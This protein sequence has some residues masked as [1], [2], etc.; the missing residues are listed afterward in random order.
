M[1]L[2]AV[3]LLL[4]VAPPRP[5]ARLAPLVAVA[6]GVAAGAALSVVVVRRRPG[7]A[8]PRLRTTV[9][10]AKQLVLGLCATNEEIVWRRIA[11]GELLPAGALV[12]LGSSSVGFA[13]VHRKSRLLHVGT[14]CTFGVVY[15]ATGG[16]GASVAAHWAY[17]AFVGA[18]VSR[19]PS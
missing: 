3:A 6:A 2:L 16:L 11:L 7:R 4:V 13:L 15:L 5:H 14:G 19:S 17:N 18:L 12:A 9:A 10:V 8:G 1:T